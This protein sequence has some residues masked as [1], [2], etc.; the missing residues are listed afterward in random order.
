[1]R[2]YS[3]QAIFDQEKLSSAKI[4]IIGAGALTNYLCLYLS[5]LGIK[6]T[7]VIDDSQY[8]SEPNEFL[9]KNFEGGKVKGL[10][11]KIKDINQE[12]KFTGISNP[13]LDFLIGQPDVLIDLTNSPESKNKCK[14][15]SKKIYSIKKVISASSSENNG[16]LRVYTPQ[17]GNTLI[18]KKDPSKVLFLEKDDFSLNNYKG[19]YQGSFTSGLIAAITLDEI[20]KTVMPLENEHPLMKKAD[21]SLYSENRFNS[22]L[23]FDEKKEDLS[24]LNAL[25]VGAGGIGT[26]VC[27]NLALMGVGNVDLYDGDVVE[28]HNLNRQVFYYDKVGFKK[29]DVLAER[30]NK[31]TSA[32]ITAH[33]SYLKDVSQL[34]KKYDLIFSCLDNWQ[35]R[36][37]LSD[38][39]V[40]K[41]IPFINGS[42]TTFNAYADINN[43]LMCKHN[44]ETLL[45]REKDLEQRAGSCSNVANSNVVMANAFI[46]ALMASET[47]AL[48]FPYKYKPLL[49]KQFSY[50]SQ[51]VD[52]L[53]F[54][55][56][57]P[58]LSC[59]CHKKNKGCE[60]HENRTVLPK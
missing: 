22:G 25:V 52:S 46:G 6:N 49:K 45:E 58:V 19:L 7:T 20:R 23:K 29:A 26:Y 33:T 60:C 11:K 4:M 27:L 59:L 31:L 2:D 24:K 3:R 37:M 40:R 56:R 9:L 41:R 1:M 21:F 15:I 51:S 8:K 50:N 47:K 32:N 39:A 30:L 10:E 43:C 38:Y 34:K 53:K 54:N 55:I 48:A 12:I 13:L 57:D 16:S 18:L 44:S 36:F 35:Y 17:G 14:E 42:V 5:G 28:N